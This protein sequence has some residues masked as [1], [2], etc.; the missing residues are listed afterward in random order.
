MTGVLMSMAGTGVPGMTMGLMAP[1][2]K[3]VPHLIAGAVL[4]WFYGRQLGRLRLA[5]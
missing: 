1:M 3:L 4:S 5:Q 2:V